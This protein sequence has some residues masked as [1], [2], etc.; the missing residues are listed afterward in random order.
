MSRLIFLAVIQCLALTAGQVMLK[1]AMQTMGV[2]T[3]TWTFIRSQ[4]VNWWWLGCGIAFLSAGMLWMYILRHY[5]FSLA[6]PLASLSYVFGMLAAVGIFHEQV[7]FAQWIG[8]LFIMAGCYL[9]M[10]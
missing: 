7:S 6:Y 2:V 9:I 4:L 3:F 8:V 10:K 5:P 1:L